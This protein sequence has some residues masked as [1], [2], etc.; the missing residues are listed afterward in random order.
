MTAHATSTVL[1]SVEEY[2]YMLEKS[3]VKLEYRAGKVVAMALRWQELSLR[4][5]SLQ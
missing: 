2:L 5:I 3:D 4:I 1:V